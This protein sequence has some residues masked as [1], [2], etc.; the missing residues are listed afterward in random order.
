MWNV[1]VNRLLACCVLMQL[2]MI[3]SEFSLSVLNPALILLATGLIRD[4]WIDCVAAAPPLLFILAFKI[5]I[6]RTAERQFRYYEASPEEVEQETMYS[7]SEEKPM[8][9]QSDVE[10]RFLHP[11][12]QHNKLYTVMVHKS[13]ESL[14]REVLSAYPWFAG[15]HEHEGVAIKAVREVSFEIVSFVW[16]LFW[17][18]TRW[19]VLYRKIWNTIRLEMD[20]RTK[21]T[22][23]TGTRNPWHRPISYRDTITRLLPRITKTPTNITQYRL[24]TLPHWP[25]PV[26][27]W[28]IRPRTSCYPRMSGLSS[29]RLVRRREASRVG[30]IIMIIR[31]CRPARGMRRTCR[32]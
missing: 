12:L 18:L 29:L 2:L 13:Q 24:R 8:M 27:L 23:R 32:M 14:A 1:Y 3:L 19:G 9:K 4:R 11:A 17:W 25:L 22:K 30:R 15:K 10:N 16:G 6:S 26:Y 7:M 28:I 21:C 5:Y 20:R 31:P